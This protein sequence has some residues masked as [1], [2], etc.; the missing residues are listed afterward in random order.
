MT[1]G[2]ELI[3]EH[4]QKTYELTLAMWEQ[5]NRT[6]LILLATVGIATLLTFN[7]S[8]AQPLLVDLIANAVGIEEE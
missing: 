5:R 3:A 4:Y 8:Q 7:V 1:P 2:T 6:F